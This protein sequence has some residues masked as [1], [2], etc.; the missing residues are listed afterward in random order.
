MAGVTA[1]IGLG[2]NLGDPVIQLN[3]AVQALSAL[4]MAELL[5]VS[6]FYGNPPMGPQDQPDYVNAAAL[7]RTTLAP[8]E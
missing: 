3:R 8:L 7:Q 6:G 2:S 4:P 1:A 5:A